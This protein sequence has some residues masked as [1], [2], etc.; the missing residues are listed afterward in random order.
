MA[1]FNQTQLTLPS[2]PLSELSGSD[3]NVE[4]FSFGGGGAAIVT[5]YINRVYDTV[6]SS[7]VRWDTTPTPDTTGASYP[8][9]GTWGVNTSDYCVERVYEA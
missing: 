9:P 5:H 7:F 4:F 2:T 6:A 3:A 1:D 8:G